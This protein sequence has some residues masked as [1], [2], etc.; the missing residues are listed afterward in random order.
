M[1]TL[2]STHFKS[3][4]DGI[5]TFSNHK[6]ELLTKVSPIR[7]QEFEL[8]PIVRKW[9]SQY[10]SDNQYI[11]SSQEPEVN[12]R[13]TQAASIPMMFCIILQYAH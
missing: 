8:I 9:H 6:K 3:S 1:L 12:D 11:L 7:N 4:C 5:L 2:S 10:A 13:P